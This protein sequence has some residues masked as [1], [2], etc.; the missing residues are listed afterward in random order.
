MKL[1]KNRNPLWET[2]PKERVSYYSFFIGQNMIYCMIS[3]FLVAYLTFV[4]IDPT[5]SATVM[6][7]IKIWDAVNDAIFGVIFDKAKFKSGLKFRPWLKISCALTPVATFL[8]FAIPKGSSETVKLAWFAVAYLIWD[9]V[10]TLSDAPAYGLITVMTGNIEERNTILSYKSIMGGVGNGIATVLATILTSEYLGLSYTWVGLVVAIGAAFTMYPIAINCQE[11][12]QLKKEEKEQEFT[13]KMMLSYLVKNKYLLIYYLGFFFYSAFQTYTTLHQIMAYYV[14]GNSLAALVATSV[15]VV[16]QL[17]MS[18]LTPQIV[19]KIDKMTFFRWCCALA[20]IF[21]IACIPTKSSFILFIIFTTLKNIPIGAMGI[22]LFIFTPDCAEYGEYKTGNEAKGITFSIQTFMVKLCAAFQSSL[23]LYILGLF[24]YK[25]IEGADNFQA[26]ENLG[27]AAAQTPH[28]I[29][30]IWF[31]YSVFP[32]IG[33]VAAFIIW[34]FYKLNDKDVQ[35]MADCNAGKIT[36]EQA[37]SM[38]SRDYLKKG[39]PKVK[40]IERPHTEEEVKQEASVSSD[41]SKDEG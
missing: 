16:P 41:S 1:V 5:K 40:K 23:A 10:Y 8:I 25:T 13:V 7:I 19:R 21:S 20:I 39:D 14:F 35:I 36:R 34:M 3:S 28:A 6:L 12:N 30:G 18:V 31:A 32:V 2:Q 27:E 9:S 22:L 29:D 38:L 24:G 11:R 26:L 17:V 37:Q 15:A 4:G 33:L